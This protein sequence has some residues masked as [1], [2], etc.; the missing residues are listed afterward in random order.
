MPLHRCWLRLC[1]VD[2]VGARASALADQAEQEN[3]IA[4]ASEF[5]RQDSAA[6]DKKDLSISFYFSFNSSFDSGFIIM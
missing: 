1:A 3:M 5:A 6:G 2:A 4:G